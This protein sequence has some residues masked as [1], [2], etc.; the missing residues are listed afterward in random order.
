MKIA[1]L[2]TGAVG[3]TIAARLI[4]LGHSVV[5]GSREITNEKALTIVKNLGSKCSNNTFNVACAEAEL[6][7][8]CTAGKAW[9]QVFASID[10]K[11]LT[12]KVLIDLS[13]PL[14][15]SNGMPPTLTVCNTSSIGELL[16]AKFKNTFVV[17][18]LNTMWCGLMVNPNQLNNGDHSVFVSSNSAEAKASAS[19]ILKAFGWKTENIIDLGDI[20]SARGTEMYL[21]LWLRLYGVEKSSK[22]NIKLVR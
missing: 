11:N 22:I 3:A 1:V 6:V 14:D 17:K 10:E 16:Q 19:S 9:E 2:G 7:F 15:F 8:N 18:T 13:N 20:T 5:I 12:N 21:P 4:E